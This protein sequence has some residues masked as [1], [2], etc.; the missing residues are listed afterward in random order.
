MQQ[1]EES[2]CD[3][4]KEKVE[5]AHRRGTRK[6]DTSVLVVSFLLFKIGEDQKRHR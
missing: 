5:K 2:I 6:K 1:D 3:E 4:M